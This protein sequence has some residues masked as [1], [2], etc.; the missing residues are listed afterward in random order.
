[1]MRSNR[2]GRSKVEG[3]GKRTG[4]REDV[5]LMLTKVVNRGETSEYFQETI[6]LTLTFG[7]VGVC[8]RKVDCHLQRSRLFGC[9]LLP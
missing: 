4:S 1:V 9:A 8:C 2:E 6:W 7:E 3:E 5:S